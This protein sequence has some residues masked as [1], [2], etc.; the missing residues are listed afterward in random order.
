MG[1]WQIIM[2]VMLAMS[3]GIAIAEHGKPKAGK[4]NAWVAII[5]TVIIAAILIMG[6]FFS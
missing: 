2:I 3:L 5:S 4:H 6:G 1:I